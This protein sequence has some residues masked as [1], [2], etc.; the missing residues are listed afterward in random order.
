MSCHP[1]YLSSFNAIGGG[2][3]LGWLYL[4]NSN[5]DW[6]QYVDALGVELKKLGIEEITNMVW[7]IPQSLAFPGI[8]IMSAD[9]TSR[10]DPVVSFTP[11]RRRLYYQDGRYRTIPTRYVAVSVNSMLGLYTGEDFRWLWRQRLVK[12]VNDSIFIFD[13]DRLTETPFFR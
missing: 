8:R 6:C 7:G 10:G 11:P 12:R 13:M 9:E 2:P 3:R 4:A 5:I 1:R